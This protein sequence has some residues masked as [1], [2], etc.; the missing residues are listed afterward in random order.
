MKKR[1]NTVIWENTLHDQFPD[2]EMNILAKM[3][4]QDV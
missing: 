2:R 3:I 4:D 1:K